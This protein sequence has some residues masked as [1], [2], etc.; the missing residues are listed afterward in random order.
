VDLIRGAEATVISGLHGTLYSIKYGKPFILVNNESTNQKVRLALEKTGQ[1][2]R[3]FERSELDAA[4][5][6]L[7]EP[8]G[9]ALPQ[10]PV[11]W[12]ARSQGFLQEAI[13]FQNRQPE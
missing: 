2:F 6:D 7:L 3:I 8:S 5:L 13:A 11:D 1:N 10:V 9:G 12:V 4:A